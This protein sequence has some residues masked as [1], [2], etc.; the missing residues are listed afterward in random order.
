MIREAD[1]ILASFGEFIRESQTQEPAQNNATNADGGGGDNADPETAVIVAGDDDSNPVAPD[2]TAAAPV[3][4]SRVSVNATNVDLDDSCII[5]MG[6]PAQ[7][8]SIKP[9]ARVEDEEDVIF[10]TESR[11]P[12]R[13]LGTIDLCDSPKP[14]TPSPS[15][16]P[17]TTA[18]AAPAKDPSP[19]KA[20]IGKTKCPICLDMFTMDEILSTMCG[21]LFCAPCINSV[22]KSRKKCPMCNRGLKQNQLHR[23]FIDQTL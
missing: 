9:I 19:Q 21:H 5:I 7:F 4:T 13:I 3:S 22:I 10:V 12:Q 8:R 11:Q 23:I 16:P 18:A 2:T 14:A 17:T 15:P 1:I 20:T 6:D